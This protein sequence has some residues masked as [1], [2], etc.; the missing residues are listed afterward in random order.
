MV[1][2]IKFFDLINFEESP[3]GASPLCARVTPWNISKSQDGLGWPM[4]WSKP[5]GKSLNWRTGRGYEA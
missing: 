1:N 2:I 3:G 5:N 4:H